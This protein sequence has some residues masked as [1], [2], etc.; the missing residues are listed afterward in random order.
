MIM[1]ISRRRAIAN[2]YLKTHRCHEGA[3]EAMRASLLVHS[4]RTGSE[5][6]HAFERATM[7]AR[8]SSRKTV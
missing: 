6:A 2:L 1:I 8:A 3:E 7:D 4:C 5:E